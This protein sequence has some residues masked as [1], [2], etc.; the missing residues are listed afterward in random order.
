MDALE[1]GNSKKPR[2]ESEPLPKAQH[3]TGES[4]GVPKTRNPPSGLFRLPS[5]AGSTGSTQPHSTA[6]A[7]PKR[8]SARRSKRGEKKSTSSQSAE[9]SLMGKEGPQRTSS[10][11]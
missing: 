5:T 2:S 7:R 1:E 8:L 6:G 11:T 9:R 10:P 3:R 4:T